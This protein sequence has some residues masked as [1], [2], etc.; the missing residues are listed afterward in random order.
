MDKK[1]IIEG[2][3]WLDAV[4]TTLSAIGNTPFTFLET[5]TL[6]RIDLV[7]DSLQATASAIM[8]DAEENYNL[9][10]I[11]NMIDASG[12]VIEIAGN[13]LPFANPI[14]NQFLQAEGNGL[15]TFGTGLTFI[16]CYENAIETEFELSALYG[17]Y[18]SLIQTIGL[19]MQTIAAL[20]PEDHETGK[21]LNTVGCWV[22]AIGAIL[23]AIGCSLE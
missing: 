18:G 13:N 9:F 12:N 8:A 15:Q 5:D 11:G 20:L 4:G 7:G 2:A 14:S 16:Y 6:K 10:K 19:A 3:T 23:E 22:Q 17:I 1:Q 21:R